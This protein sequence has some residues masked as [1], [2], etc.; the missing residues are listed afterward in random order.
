MPSVGNRQ[1][2]SGSFRANLVGGLSL[3]IQL[4]NNGTLPFTL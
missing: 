3:G 2:S 4:G 1:L